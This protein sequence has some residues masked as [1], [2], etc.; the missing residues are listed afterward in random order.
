MKK[1][2]LIKFII[3]PAVIIGVITGATIFTFAGSVNSN[4]LTKQEVLKIANKQIKSEYFKTDYQTQGK[5]L[6]LGSSFIDVYDINDTLYAYIVPLISENEGEI[7][8][9]TVGALKDGLDIY[10]SS[11]GNTKTS[12]LNDKVNKQKKSKS[13]KVKLVYLPDYSYATKVTSGT[14]QSTYIEVNSDT[15]ISKSVESHKV[16]YNKVYKKFRSTQNKQTISNLLSTKISTP[17]ANNISVMSVPTEDVRVSD[18]PNFIKFWDT[19]F[20]GPRYTYGGDQSWWRTSYLPGR[21]I[22]GCAPV[23]A[24]NITCHLARTQSKLAA[25]Y[26][27]ALNRDDFFGHMNSVFSIMDPAP[28]GVPTLSEFANDTIAFAKNRGVTLRAHWNDQYEKFPNTLDGQANYIKSALQK[29]SPVGY[30]QVY[31]A[32]LP[33]YNP[34]FMTITKYFRGALDDTQQQRWVAISTWGT[35]VSVN[36][37]TI[38]SG[39]Y[40]GFIYFDW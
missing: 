40:F 6:T 12:E 36:F 30:M 34:H 38:N 28:Y 11:I 24:A 27:G 3:I 17:V 15:D 18:E 14:N 29:N 23:A 10:E 26:R 1:R 35:R 39:G 7:G 2:K 9:I 13:D 22:V 19:S 16:D 21:E 32:N 4:L 31:N 25:L 33:D 20:R 8:Y 37:Y 5:K